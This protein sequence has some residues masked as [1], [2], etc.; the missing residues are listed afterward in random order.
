MGYQSADNQ[1]VLLSNVPAGGSNR[2]LAVAVV[3]FSLLIFIAAIPFARIPLP[4]I[5]PFIPIYQSALVINDMITAIILFSQFSM[6]RSRAV[7][8]LASGYLF[9]A[10]VAIVHLLTFP[11]LFSASGLLGAGPQTTAWLYMAWHAG[12]PIAVIAYAFL[13]DPIHD[14]APQPKSST[15]LAVLAAVIAVLAIAYVVSLATT[16]EQDAL[17]QIMRDN[18]YSPAMIFVIGTVWALSGAALALLWRRPRPTTLDVWLMVVL[19]TWIF[20]IGLSAVFNHGRFDLGFYVGRTFGLLS[21]MFVL[22]VLL[23]EFGSMYMRLTQSLSAEH[24]ERLREIEERRRIFDT[25]LDL[26]MVTDRYGNFV[27]VSPSSSAILG[28]QPGEMIGHS[29]VEFI[30]RDDL[31]PTRSEMRSA[32]LGQGTR[33]FN[34]RYVHKDGRVVTLAWTGVWSEP[35]Q[36]HFFIGRDM[37]E[38]KAAEERLRHL[39]H[40]DQLTG[41]PNRVS[42]QNELAALI[43]QDASSVGGAASIALLDLDGFKDINDTLGHSTGDELL[44][45]VAQ[46]LTATASDHARVYRLG[47]DEFVA[48][49]AACGDP[50]RVGGL[51]DTMLTRLADPFEISGQTLFISASAGIAFAPADGSSVDELIANADLA[52]YEAKGQGGRTYRLFL[53]AYRARAQ[54]RRMLDSELRRAVSEGEFEVFYQPQVRLRDSAILGAEALVRWRHPERGLLGPDAFIDALVESPAVREVGSWILHAACSHSAAWRTRGLKP[55]RIGVNL[56]PAQFHHDSLLTDI[57]DVLS[58]TGLPADSLEL[59]ITENI[60]LNDDGKVLARL[61]ALREMGVHLAFDDFG[62]GYASLNY[63][64]RYPLS[65]IKIDQSFVRKIPNNRQDAAIV[66]SIIVMSHNLGLEVVAEGVERRDQASF[67]QDEGCDQVQ[68]FLFSRPLPNGAFAELLTSWDKNSLGEAWT[69]RRQ[70]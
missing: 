13:K 26:I 3:L 33:N 5:W 27:R 61:T 20:D 9:T 21:S 50:L 1:P 60:G 43:D 54:A 34:T 37:T 44:K 51:L 24:Q 42:L 30:H 8:V 6:A 29:A 15:A 19:C 4:E 17:P 32:R 69:L 45:A 7:L 47:G 31:D 48:V 46:R 62:T 12:F 57:E 38:A 59:E 22:T 52:L 56:F 10:A 16:I 18:G 41:L 2:R 67:L 53:P 36:R 14:A 70:A 39:A 40:Y 55:I 64:T 68:G 23:V 25:S 35:E 65:R 63:L 58:Q 49:L 11:G 28:Y 66:R